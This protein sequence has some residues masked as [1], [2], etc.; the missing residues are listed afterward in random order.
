[1]TG[2]Y[3]RKRST[4]YSCHSALAASFVLTSPDEREIMMAS[5]ASIDPK[6]LRIYLLPDG[7][8]GLECITISPAEN[9]SLFGDKGVRPPRQIED[10]VDECL[11]L[12]ADIPDAPDR[13]AL[14]HLATDLK[15]SLAKVEMALATMPQK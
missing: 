3:L 8:V 14:R 1:M 6:D 2:R 4:N 11:Q 15:S 7:G 13:N 12:V 9:L 5:Q 10:L